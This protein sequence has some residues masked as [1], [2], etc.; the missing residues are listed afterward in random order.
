ML[1][2]YLYRKLIEERMGKK[3]PSKEEKPE[4]QPEKKQEKPKEKEK[5][6]VK[7]SKKELHNV[8]ENPSLFAGIVIG[9]LGGVLGNLIVFSAQ[10]AID[11]ISSGNSWVIF[12]AALGGFIVVL[13]FLLS[14]LRL[15]MYR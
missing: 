1:R 14:K 13:W 8:H 5:K 4:N 11:S 7:K 12:L 3:E 10:D 15:S 9:L 6:Q 2:G